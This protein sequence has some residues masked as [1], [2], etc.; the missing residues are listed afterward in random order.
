MRIRLLCTWIR[1]DRARFTPGEQCGAIRFECLDVN[2]VTATVSHPLWARESGLPAPDLAP[3]APQPMTTLQPNADA[4]PFDF[5]LSRSTARIGMSVQR[6]TL[7]RV[8]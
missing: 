2:R 7:S 8:A 6:V 4:G 5:P 1:R 3:A